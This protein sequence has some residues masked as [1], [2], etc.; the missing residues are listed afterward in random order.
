MTWDRPR[1]IANKRLPFDIAV[2]AEATRGALVYPACDTDRS[3]GAH[4]G[5]LYCSWMDLTA[6]GDTDILA[7]FSDDARSTWSAAAP[8]T[9]RLPGVERFNQWMSVDAVTG[10]VNP[11]FYDTRNDTTGARYMTDFYFAQSR[12]GGASWLTNV[13][14]SNVSSN[15]HGCGGLFPCPGI[16]YGNQQGD[17]AGLVS[18]GG[19]SHPI[20]TDSRDQLDPLAGVPSRSGDG[21]SV[22]RHGRTEE[23]GLIATACLARPRI[24]RITRIRLFVWIRVIREIRGRKRQD[25]RDPCF[26][27]AM[28]SSTAVQYASSVGTASL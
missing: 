21:G 7:S 24:T 11:A 4:R 23:V 8:V 25:Q 12:T 17:Y 14:V 20:W 18:Y 28:N 26:S 9:D 22:H 10:D 27:R 1:T 19:V 15:E 13:R 2:P 16:D 3:A 6:A 5:R